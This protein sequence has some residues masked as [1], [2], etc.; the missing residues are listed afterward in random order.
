MVARYAFK[1]LRLKVS[2]LELPKK[3]RSK[4]YPQKKRPG[5]VRVG[6]PK[7]FPGILHRYTNYREN[8][9]LLWH[10]SEKRFI[11]SY[12]NLLYKFIRTAQHW[13]L[14]KK[15]NYKFPLL[16]NALTK[17]ILDKS[18]DKN[19]RKEK[20]LFQYA[21]Y[22]MASELVERKGLYWVKE[23]FKFLGWASA[24]AQ[25]VYAE[26]KKKKIETIKKNQAYLAKYG[27]LRPIVESEL[28]SADLKRKAILGPFFFF[29]NKVNTYKKNKQK[30]K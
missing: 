15:D 27:K 29:K 2:Q 19:A 13:Y 1:Y 12:R 18:H 6:T 28:T 3:F 23:E 7:L 16:K 8:L 26:E 5:G 30:S 14:K 20:R 25:V 10:L 4:T 9:K 21:Y 22:Q 17:Y 11:L 24:A